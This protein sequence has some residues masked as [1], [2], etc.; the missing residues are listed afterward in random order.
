MWWIIASGAL[1]NLVMYALGAFSTSYYIRYHGIEIDIANRF[2]AL[3]FGL[4]G[5]LGMLIGGWFGDRAGRTGAAGRLRLAMV[6]CLCAAPLFWLALEQPQGAPARF[7]AM[8][9]CAVLAIYLYYSCVYAAIHDIVPS[10]PVLGS[11]FANSASST[12][13]LPSGAARAPS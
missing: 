12:G 11:F 6:G 10:G 8:L 5:G 9:F 1:M 4:G 3:V 13:D 7:A 2:N